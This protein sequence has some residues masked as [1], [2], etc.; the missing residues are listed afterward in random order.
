VD[1]AAAPVAATDLADR[2]WSSVLRVRRLQL[3]RTVRVGCTN[4]ISLQIHGFQDSTNG[5]FVDATPSPEL[6][7]SPGS[8]S[9]TPYLTQ[10]RTFRGRQGR[11]IRR[12]TSQ[13]FGVIRVGRHHSV[14]PVN[15]DDPAV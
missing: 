11:A 14:P 6:D 3:E 4:T 13:F 10:M 7:A 5:E 9:S 12:S 8:G 2:R 1:E 15:P